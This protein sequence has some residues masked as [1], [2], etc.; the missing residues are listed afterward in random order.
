MRG[1]NFLV[2]R[3]HEI[4]NEA[5]CSEPPV[6]CTHRAGPGVGTYF[7]LGGMSGQSRRDA[8]SVMRPGEGHKEG[9]THRHP[10]CRDVF[11]RTKTTP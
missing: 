6:A 2:H 4:Q 9:G 11:L 5:G 10:W 1:L 3:D 7:F 8:W